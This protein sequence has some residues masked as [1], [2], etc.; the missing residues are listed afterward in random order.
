MEALILAVVGLAFH[1]LR[2]RIGDM[3]TDKNMRMYRKVLGDRAD[4]KETWFRKINRW[5]L[6]FVAI[7]LLLGAYTT[8]FGPLAINL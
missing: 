8:A 3:I 4:S 6:T 7:I 5:G 1:I 2:N